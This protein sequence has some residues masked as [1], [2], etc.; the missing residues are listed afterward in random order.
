MDEE[1]ISIFL[2]IYLSIEK[3]F[4]AWDFLEL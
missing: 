2:F 4:S 3:L 1:G